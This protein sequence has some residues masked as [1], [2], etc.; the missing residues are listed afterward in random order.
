M[1]QITS[2]SSTENIKNNHL[3]H[4]YDDLNDVKYQLHNIENCANCSYLMIDSNGRCEID[5]LDMNKYIYYDQ[6]WISKS[7]G[8]SIMI[9][10]YTTLDVKEDSNIIACDVKQNY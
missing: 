3:N 2:Y 8:S 9:S 4:C 1:G 10:L 7:D 5:K 6:K